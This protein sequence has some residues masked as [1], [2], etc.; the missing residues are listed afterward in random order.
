LTEDEVAT[1]LKALEDA[2]HK[3]VFTMSAVARQGIF[4]CLRELCKYVSHKKKKTEDVEV[5]QVKKT[6]SP[7]D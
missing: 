1:K 3:K 6:W 4:D 7:L 5:V 2:I